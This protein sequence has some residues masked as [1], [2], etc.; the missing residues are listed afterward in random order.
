[1][2][3][4][5]D[6]TDVVIKELPIK[7]DVVKYIL[8]KFKV[9]FETEDNHDMLLYK[10]RNAYFTSIFVKQDVD[11]VLDYLNNNE[12]FKEADMLYKDSLFKT[13]NDASI[14]YYEVKENGGFEFYPNEYTTTV[15]TMDSLGYV[16]FIIKCIAYDK[17][18]DNVKSRN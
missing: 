1:M 5:K 3:D 16:L 15:E 14:T 9:E 7:D 6:I 13:G 8:N 11:Y 4:F 12:D 18:E 2:N 17:G 10:M